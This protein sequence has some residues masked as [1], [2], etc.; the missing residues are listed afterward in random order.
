MPEPATPANEGGKDETSC[1]GPSCCDGGQAD[2]GSPSDQLTQ[3]VQE[4]YGAAARRVL[5]GS[6]SGAAASGV[7]AS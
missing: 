6:P 2:A 3:T 4:K 5:Q 7:S 1:C